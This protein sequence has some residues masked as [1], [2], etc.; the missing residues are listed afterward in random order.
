M[1]VTEGGGVKN[2][3]SPVL[4]IRKTDTNISS[5]LKT[6]QYTVFIKLKHKRNYSK[7]NQTTICEIF[8]PPQGIGLEVVESPIPNATKS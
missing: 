3:Y 6:W 4:Q 2:R 8:N 1:W 5:L 7:N